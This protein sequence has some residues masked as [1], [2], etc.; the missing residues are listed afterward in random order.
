M[1]QNARREVLAA[2]PMVDDLAREHVHEHGVHGKIPAAAGFQRGKSGVHTDVEIRMARA[3]A[4]FA[5]RHG[6]IEVRVFQRQHAKGRAL[7]KDAPLFG[8]HRA[9][10]PG[11][12]A[13]D[14]DVD[15]LG[16]AAQQAVAH[17]AADK[18]SAPA[19]LR[20]SFRQ[21][22]GDLHFPHTPSKTVQSLKKR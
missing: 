18:I 16:I 14:L 22:A 5:A 12:N 20:H 9:Q 4:R 8:E 6:N 10:T 2:V 3:R 11:R 21:T 13:I 15:V 1:A 7:F 19:R 17:I